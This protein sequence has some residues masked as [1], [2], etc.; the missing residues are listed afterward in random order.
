M[1]ERE[2]VSVC[3][4]VCYL[5]LCTWVCSHVHVPCLSV[6]MCTVCLHTCVNLCTRGHLCVC[7]SSSPTGVSSCDAESEE[8]QGHRGE[9]TSPLTGSGPDSCHW[10]AARQGELHPGAQKAMPAPQPG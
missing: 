8:G 3:T 2:H 7:V 6:S 10:Q 1:C 4:A 9:E 5:P